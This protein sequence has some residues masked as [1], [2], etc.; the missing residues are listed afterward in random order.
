MYINN[1]QFKDIKYK[2]Y[3]Y[4]DKIMIETDE[5]KKNIYLE[6]IIMYYREYK[7]K[8]YNLYDDSRCGYPS[9]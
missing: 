4:L 6:K 2:L 9:I 7:N 1:Y 5:D 8:K 3:K